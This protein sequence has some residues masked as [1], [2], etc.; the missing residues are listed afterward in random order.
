MAY[1]TETWIKAKKGK[2]LVLRL[3]NVHLNIE[4]LPVFRNAIVTIGSF[5]GVHRGHQKILR[6]LNDLAQK[7]KGESVVVSF[8]PHPRSVIYPK[9]ESL[10]LLST[11]DEKLQLFEQYGVD[12]VVIVPFTIEFSQLKARE[13][14]EKFLIGKFH[15]HTLVVGYDHRFGLN[16]EGSFSLLKKYEENGAFRLERIEKQEL[17]RIGISST[18]I[19][20][21][22]NK[23]DILQANQLLNHPYSMIGKV[24]HGK[25][26]GK[27]LGFPTANLIIDGKKKLIPPDGIYAVHI[28]I[29]KQ[30]YSGM[31]Y[32]GQRKTLGSDASPSIEVHI[33]DFT[34]DLYDEKITVHFLSFIRPDAEFESLDD[35][36][37][38]LKQ[39][40]QQVQRYFSSHLPSTATVGLVFLNYNGLPFLKKYMSSWFQSGYPHAEIIIADNGST[41][42]SLQW[43]RENY[44]EVLCLELGENHGFAGGYN[45]A[46]RQLDHDYFALINTD[47]EL[48][49]GWLKPLILRMEGN[50][51][52]A[53][54][55]PKI[56]DATNR[57]LFE[58]AGAAGGLIDILGFPFCRGRI[59]H[60]IEQ[61]DGQYDQEQE[62][63][64]SSGAAFVI[65]ADL[66]HALGGFDEQYFA[67]QE[68]IDLC[69]RIKRAGYRVLACPGSVVYHQGG[70]TLG[71]ERP[72]KVFLNFRNNLATLFKN[73]SFG[74]LLWLIPLRLLLDWLAAARFLVTGKVKNC[75]AVFKA[76]INFIL[77]IPALI[78]KR[79]R[80]QYMINHNSL[81]PRENL[82]GEYQRSI[83]IDFYLRGYVKYSELPMEE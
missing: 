17:Q 72:R 55:Q 4:K 75:L 76:Q 15:P 82:R 47:V 19:R 80:Y 39:D 41:D 43:L 2:S 25:K 22:L 6:K 49:E 51:S 57:S 38:Q 37:I 83:L 69:W 71:Y 46:L 7:V 65:K 5:D 73:C 21:A 27:K 70:G 74:K 40:Q 61:D 42:D 66:Y 23:A 67:H 44:P 11:L 29:D 28:N 59:L 9:D 58:Y 18:K 52:I 79:W 16:R 24:I 10:Q 34:D 78:R 26:L 64:W 56:L 20:T 35:L 63:F 36:T 31:L 8:E 81:V 14:V 68:E 62:I 33:F 3:M 30:Q 1:W 12:H 60:E 53:V 54:C 50:Q 32:I 45:L 77:W 48:T 13:Y